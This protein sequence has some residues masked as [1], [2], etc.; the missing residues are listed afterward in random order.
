[1]YEEVDVG[2]A[3]C[4]GETKSRLS[5]ADSQQ[6]WQDSE[7]HKLFAHAFPNAGSQA[8]QMKSGI[9]PT[10]KTLG[11]LSTT[12][13]GYQTAPHQESQ[14]PFPQPSADY[15]YFSMPPDRVSSEPELS[16]ECETVVSTESEGPVSQVDID[17]QFTQLASFD[18]LLAESEQ[19][20]SDAY[21][22]SKL[23]WDDFLESNML[24]SS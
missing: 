4:Y 11:D 8:R 22:T 9:Y 2:A 13:S 10:Q 23:Q 3:S 21:L 5:A 19:A 17:C 16:A 18:T 24:G 1:M 12:F 15:D 6:E 7:I 20:S 14:Q